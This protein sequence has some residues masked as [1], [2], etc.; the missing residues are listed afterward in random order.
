MA[1]DPHR[2]SFHERLALFQG[3]QEGSNNSVPSLS[4]L[5]EHASAFT[6][7][8]MNGDSLTEIDLDDEQSSESDQTDQPLSKAKEDG[9]ED[10]PE[11]ELL[12]ILDEAIP[13]PVG[14][15]GDHAAFFDVSALDEDR[16]RQRLASY[17]EDWYELL[18]SKEPLYS[19]A[20]T[21]FLCH[22]GREDVFEG[23]AQLLRKDKFK[24]VL[25]SVSRLN[26]RAGHVACPEGF[27]VVFSQNLGQYYVVYRRDKRHQV[28]DLFSLE[29]EEPPRSWITARQLFF[30][31][32]EL[33]EAELKQLEK[34]HDE[35]LV[36]RESSDEPMWSIA[37]T[38]QLCEE[39]REAIFKGKA[40]LLKKDEFTSVQGAIARLNSSE[41]HLA[42][43]EG[44]CI[45]FSQ[46]RKHYFVAYRHDRKMAIFY[47]FRKELLNNW[48]R[49][50]QSFFVVPHFG[51]S[52]EK[53]DREKL[54]DEDWFTLDLTGEDMWSLELTHQLCDEGQETKFEGKAG[55]L[56][57][58]EFA[59]VRDAIPRLNTWEGH[60]ACPEGF[61]VVF[62]ENRKQYFIIY[63]RDKKETVFEL[64]ELE[65]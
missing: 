9:Q 62:S 20:Q 39:G 18:P 15:L 6:Q 57:K 53:R 55:L 56:K 51:R 7:S 8:T 40:A 45:V 34:L 41:G 44:F 60:I 58:D 11:A 2:L 12:D 29:D 22:H 4:W 63:R 64:F 30:T 13:G 1:A 59:S 52:A 35:D 61:C 21:A 49:V 65:R 37:R 23:R 25:E 48:F 24:S 46:A 36:K 10:Q 32:S 27:C 14:W 31:T 50:R 38:L 17:D 28:F 33:S 47:L 19:V 54:Y 3:D 43:P 16:L 26:T 5:K 42:C